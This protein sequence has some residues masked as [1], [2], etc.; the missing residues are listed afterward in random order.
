MPFQSF[1]FS[2]NKKAL[3]ELLFFVEIKLDDKLHIKDL[4]RYTFTQTIFG[5]WQ[6]SNIDVWDFIYDDNDNLS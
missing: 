1:A 6:S 4:I 5:V 3:S 2:Q